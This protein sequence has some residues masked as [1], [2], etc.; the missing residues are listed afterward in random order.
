MRFSEKD[1]SSCCCYVLFLLSF[2]YA[3]EKRSFCWFWN[4]RLPK[5]VWGKTSTWHD[6]LVRGRRRCSSSGS[7]STV[8]VGEIEM[9]NPSSAFS[10]WAVHWLDNTGQLDVSQCKAWWVEREMHQRLGFKG[11]TSVKLVWPIKFWLL[12]LLRLCY[13]GERSLSCHRRSVYSW[14]RT[15]LS[16]D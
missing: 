16:T 6:K 5:L 15:Y 7:R 4:V 8:M 9:R 10:S 14:L 13:N 3:Q 1:G 12:H 11:E 2:W